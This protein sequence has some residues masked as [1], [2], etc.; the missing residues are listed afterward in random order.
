M[1]TAKCGCVVDVSK[2]WIEKHCKVLEDALRL[3]STGK[4]FNPDPDSFMKNYQI[5]QEHIIAV[6][7][8]V[9][10]LQ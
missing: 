6:K 3:S 10:L 8:E 2:N 1:Q 4:N 5:A 9:G 7:K